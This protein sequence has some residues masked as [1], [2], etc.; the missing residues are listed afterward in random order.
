[1]LHKIKF[2][3][4]IDFFCQG[5][6]SIAHPGPPLNPPCSKEHDKKIDQ[7]PEHMEVV[8]LVMEELEGLRDILKRFG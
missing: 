5:G 2:H 1:M 4:Y 6:P 3:N 8:I 7:H